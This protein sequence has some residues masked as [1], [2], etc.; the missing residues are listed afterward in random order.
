MTSLYLKKLIVTCVLILGLAAS[1]CGC[2]SDKELNSY[3]Q[4]IQ[5]LNNQQFK[6]ALDCFNAYEATGKNLGLTY[7]G[8]G[9]AYLGLGEYDKALSAFQMALDQSNGLLKKV[10]FDIN[11]YMAVAEVK[12]GK[13]DDAIKTYSSIIQVNK[14]SSD[15]YYLRGKVNLEKDNLSD[16]KADFDKAIELDKDNP[17][18]YINIHK[19]L[20]SH[21]YDADAKAYINTGVAT[22]S[23]PTPYELGIFNYYLGDYTQARNYFEE[24]SDTKKTE[25]GIVYLGKTY[26]ALN[27]AA[28]ATA[29]YEE[30]INNN[31]TA[32]IVCNEL[33]LLKAATK[34]YE[35]AKAAFDSG[36]QVD[37]PSCKQALL[38]N[39][40]VANE[41]LGN[42]AEAE[43][44]MKSYLAQFPDDKNAQREDIFLSSR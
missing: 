17:K 9:M 4:G 12:S 14:N 27:D 40:I 34:D 29:L 23:K 28:Y 15:A 38:F 19:D 42:F 32:A 13:Y 21:G 33:G 11:Y 26:V 43:K 44:D 35:G 16:A 5:A 18:L 2:N 39:K 8:K 22:V 7:R 10:D 1:I 36:L 6:E 3:E 31:K 25:E 20:L 30:Y 24:A 37:N 41:Y